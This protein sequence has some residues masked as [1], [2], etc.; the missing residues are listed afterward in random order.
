[1]GFSACGFARAGAVDKEAVDAYRRWLSRGNNGEMRY[2]ENH[3]AVR[4]DTRLMLD[5]AKTVIS[6]ALNYFP[7]QTTL[8]SA[9]QFAYYAYGCDYHDVMRERLEKLAD[10][11]RGRYG[12]ETRCCVDTAPVRERWWAR[13]SGLGI[14]GLNGQLIIPGRG[15][16]FF[17]GEVITT[18][19][20]PADEPRRQS[21]GNCM[22]CVNACPGGAL[23]GDGTLDARR[24]LSYL[25]IEYRGERLPE[26]SAR[27]LGNRVY[28]CDE[29]QKVCPHN[30]RATATDVEEFAPSEEFFWLDKRKMRQM[31]PDDFRRIFRRSAVRRTK[32]S[33]LMRN[34]AAMEGNEGE[35]VGEK[36]ISL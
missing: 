34:L 4:A 20:L 31:T 8:E 36:K 30:R 6:L 3:F 18:L 32:Y 10:F 22:R 11:I 1:M 24:C 33:G 17:L 9:P 13:R 28:G 25:T 27:R 19:E 7:K 29:C 23:L 26:D 21:C 5:G 2:L 15:S 16:Y 14:I 35:D 12:A